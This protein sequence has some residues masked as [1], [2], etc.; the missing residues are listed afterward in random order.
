MEDAKS[1]EEGLRKSGL[2]SFKVPAKYGSYAHFPGT[3]PKGT[4]CYSCSFLNLNN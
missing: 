2:G 1:K 4:T 3:G